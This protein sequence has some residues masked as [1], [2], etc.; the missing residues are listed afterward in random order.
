MAEL[1]PELTDDTQAPVLQ[2]GQDQGL[3]VEEAMSK[4]GLREQINIMAQDETSDPADAFL[5]ELVSIA[6]ELG[7]L[8][9]SFG[10]PSV[11]DQADVLDVNSDPMEFL[12]Q[13][14]LTSLVEKY[15]VI[16]EP[17][18]T[19]IGDELRKQHP[20]SMTL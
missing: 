19:Q 13:Q 10:P 4:M 2:Q 20:P 8:D 16:P 18:R 1:P 12:N 15:M 9:E 3:G 11:A 6:A 5:G 7:I 14:Q 17:Q